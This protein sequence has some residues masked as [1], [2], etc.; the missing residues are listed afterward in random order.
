MLIPLELSK[1]LGKYVNIFKQKFSLQQ[2]KNVKNFCA[3]HKC[4]CRFMRKVVYV[5][6]YYYLTISE[7]TRISWFRMYADLFS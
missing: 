1:Y 7:L 5:V 6:S 3:V 2:N 4:A